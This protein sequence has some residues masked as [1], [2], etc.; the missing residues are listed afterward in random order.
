MWLDRVRPGM[1]EDGDTVLNLVGAALVV[2][3]LVA[4]GVVALNFDPPA[5]EE[6][7]AANWTI[8]RV[9]DT[10][11]RVTHAGGDPV[12]TDELRVT[13]DSI[14]RST[15][16]SDPVTVGESTVIDASTGT[17]VRVVWQGGRANRVVMA[18][19]RV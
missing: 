13:V 14:R 12:P 6:P 17:N 1:L 15:D 16:W 7:P 5:T 18:S 10:H 3:L 4:G 8:E 9:D 11:V 2:G 19:D